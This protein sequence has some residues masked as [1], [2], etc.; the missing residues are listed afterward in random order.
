MYKTIEGIYENE[1]VKIFESVLVSKP[2]KVLVTFIDPVPSEEKQLSPTEI[3][4][5]AKE[6]AQNLK[7]M[8]V[9]REAIFTH[10]ETLI[11]EIRQDAIRRGVALNEAEITE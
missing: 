2:V 3:V 10:L 6:R 11:E 5:L 1:E 8:G 4:A 9:S 7:K